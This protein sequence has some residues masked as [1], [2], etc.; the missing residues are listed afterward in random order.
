MGGYLIALRMG[1]LPGEDLIHGLLEGRSAPRGVNGPEWLEAGIV[2][3]DVLVVGSDARE[4]ILHFVRADRDGLMTRRLLSFTTDRRASVRR[5]IFELLDQLWGRDSGWPLV[6][7]AAEPALRDVDAVVRRAAATLLVNTAEPDRAMAALCASTDPVVRIALMDAM[8]WHRVAGR[9]AIL[10]RLQSDPV[11]AI[12]LLANVATLSEDDPAAWP[13]L[14]AAIRADL[15]A[16]AA[17]LDVPGSRLQ[18]AGRLW[19]RALIR[20]DR[21]DDCCSWARRLAKPGEGPQVR[22]EGVRLAVAAMREWRA[23]P[24]RVTPILTGTLGEGPSEVRSAALNAL[25]ASLT[26]S[27][28]AADDLATVM[29]D[30]ELG[31]VAATALGSVGDHRAVPSLVRLMLSD[32]DEPRLAE[33]FR[34]VARA[35]ADPGA[36]VTAAR[37]MLAAHPDSCAPD[38]PMQVLAAFGPA[39]ATALPE[40]I[41]R[42]RGAENDTPDW[43]FYVLGRIGPAAAA[44]VPEL[45]QY[46]AQ[47]ATLALLR[48]TSDR[49]VAE[50]Y[51]AGRPDEPHRGRFESELLTWLAEHGGLTVRQ[52]KQVRSLFRAPGFE[53]VESARALWLHE[54]PA[55]APELLEVLPKYLSDD[56]YAAKALRVLAAMRPHARPV[57]D[58]LDQLVSSRHRIRFNIADLDAQMRADEMLLAATLAARNQIAG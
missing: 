51:L 48:V 15:D 33:A 21:E 53:E 47:G 57:L 27:R 11:P 22:L 38:L 12:R 16:S 50:R 49:E 18:T 26:A 30:P 54:G 4:H 29:D 45:R 43:A 42:L 20:L 34:A 55:V 17:V 10:Q 52:H 36:P 32:S 39:A 58:Q 40:L 24:G 23:A 41:A 3:G 7:D 56:R 28:L 31:A 25:A 19:A 8:P 1:A 37:Q 13:A 9:Q 2:S 14:D 44:A 5:T 46:R 6:A 35:D